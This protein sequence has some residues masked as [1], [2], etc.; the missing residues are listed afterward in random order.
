MRKIVIIITVLLV[1]GGGGFF[2]WQ[3]FI[4]EQSTTEVSDMAPDIPYGSIEGE[5]LFI[6]LD[7]LTA[8]FVRDGK[9]AHY[10]VIIVN[11]EVASRDDFD[12]V[13]IFLPRVRDAFVVELHTLATVRNPDQAMINMRR[14]KARL[15]ASVD[16]VLGEGVVRGVLVQLAQ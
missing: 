13:R 6:E 4:A 16:A 12:K 5:P 7:P 10:V 2:G 3:Q 14:V 9:F 11:L 8:P 1:L 15:T